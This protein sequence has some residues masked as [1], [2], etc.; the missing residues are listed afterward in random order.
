[1]FNTGTERLKCYYD[2]QTTVH[3]LTSGQWAV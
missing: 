3:Q 2:Q 1:M